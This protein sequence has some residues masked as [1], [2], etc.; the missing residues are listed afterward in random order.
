MILIFSAGNS[1]P[2]RKIIYSDDESD[3]ETNNTNDKA[4]EST[5]DKPE[6]NEMETNE[7]QVEVSDV[8]SKV[9]GDRQVD[10]NKEKQ[11]EVNGSEV[12][13][14]DYDLIKSP[15]KNRELEE[16]IIL[17]PLNG[18][19][20]HKMEEYFLKSA[21]NSKGVDKKSNKENLNNNNIK[22]NLDDEYEESP[23]K[24]IRVK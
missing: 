3:Y 2:K 21:K 19:N 1:K 11:N 17:E 6:V 9:Y 14:Q 10:E 13:S 16:S 12:E 7:K 20:S 22:R 15:P 23:S 4:N 18:E 8:E 5:V 24:K